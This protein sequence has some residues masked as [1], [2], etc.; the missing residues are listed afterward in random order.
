M[1]KVALLIV[2]VGASALS[3]S[4]EDVHCVGS[5]AHIL[6]YD[7][8]GEANDGSS[9]TAVENAIVSLTPSDKHASMCASSGLGDHTPSGDK[10]FCYG[11]NQDSSCKTAKTDIPLMNGEVYCEGCFVGASADLFYNLNY[12]SYSVNSVEVGLKDMH[13]R[14]GLSL[15]KQLSGSKTLVKGT[16]MLASNTSVTII[17]KLVGCP[18]CIRVAIKVATPTS[19]DYEI[20]LKGQADFTAGA[21]LDIDLGERSIKWDHVD[22][23]TASKPSRTVKVQPIL[24]VGSHQTEADIK[25]ALDTSLQVNVDDIIWYHLDFKPSFPMT[26]KEQG[27]LWPPKGKFCVKGDGALTISHEA[28]LHWKLLTFKELHH[29]G[30]HQ[31]FHWDKSGIINECKDVDGVHAPVVV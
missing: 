15:H 19:L 21:M 3:F 22:G 20:D 24:D 1:R 10:A 11:V 8:V 7:V 16:K 4:G 27:S 9:M 18:V 30:P 29:W 25:L 6:K 5:R 23:W 31:D 17:D 12:T 13:L 14:G 26:C 28:D 2:A